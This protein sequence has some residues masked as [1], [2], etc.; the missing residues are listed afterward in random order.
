MCIPVAERHV[1]ELLYYLHT[2]FLL[3]YNSVRVSVRN[4]VGGT[5][6][7]SRGQLSSDVC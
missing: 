6:I 7:I 4:V 3:L 5:S 1:R 2:F